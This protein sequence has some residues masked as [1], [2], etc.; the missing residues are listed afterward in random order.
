MT[1][2]TF[3]LRFWITFCTVISLTVIG[4]QT[5]NAQASATANATAFIAAPLTIIKVTDLQFGGFISGIGGTVTVAAAGTRVSA[6]P[7]PLA[8]SLYPV[9]AASFSLTGSP[10]YVYT[11]T[12]PGPTV[13]AGPAGS[14]MNVTVFASNPSGT[15]TLT[16]GGTSTLTVGGT[17]TLS[18]NQ[19][20]GSYTGTFS[21]TVSYQ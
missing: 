12:L 8:N 19:A 5:A 18:G 1:K 7:V 4:T 21:I 3:G 13:L 11:I 16:A 2:N 15:G 10:N 14:N 20:P 17:L 6:G 9:G